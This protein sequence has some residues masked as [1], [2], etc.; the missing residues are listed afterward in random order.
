MSGPLIAVLTIL[1]FVRR[2]N[3]FIWPLIALQTSNKFTMLVGLNSL[4]GA[5]S[6]PWM[7]S[8]P[9]PCCR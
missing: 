6:H 8:W 1:T 4:N 9:S 3:D 2:C 7:R 5:Y